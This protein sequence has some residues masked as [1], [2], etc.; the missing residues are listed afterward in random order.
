VSDLGGVNDEREGAA[1]VLRD[2]QLRRFEAFEL[3]AAGRYADVLPIAL[4]TEARYPRRGEVPF[5]LACV[6][7]EQGRP[8]R[9]L[10]VL[11]AGLDRGLWWPADWLLDDD[12]L[13]PLRGRPELADIVARSARNRPAGRVIP[14]AVVV[15]AGGDRAAPVAVVLALHGWGQAAAE[16]L[17]EWAGLAAVGIAVI[18]PESTEELT[19]GFFVWNDRAT[20]RR[21]IADQYRLAGAQLTPAGVPPED[22]PLVVAG[23]S[24]GGGLAVDLAVDGA[25]APAAGFL[26]VSSG[27]DDLEA[28]PD[29]ARL[30]RAVARGLR[31]RLVVGGADAALE[32]ARGLAA[33]AAGAG[34]SCPLT[35][36]PGAGHQMPDPASGLLLAEIEAL[37]A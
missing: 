7:C 26:A 8:D 37:L 5:W 22:V 21:T 25:P 1:T 13:T 4:E 9:A 33:A 2:F 27:L 12:D 34:L 10:E 19:P 15:G 20:A 35:V 11:R 17:A 28:P 32:S 16:F 30:R 29:A 14:Q 6:H 24:Q 3:F 23:F 36:L 31:G 18:A